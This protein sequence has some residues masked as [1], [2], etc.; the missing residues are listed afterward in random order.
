MIE[1]TEKSRVPF[2][3]KPDKGKK[4]CECS[5]SFL[6]WIV[7]TLWEGDFHVWAFHAKKILESRASLNQQI[8][9]EDQL[10]AM[11]DSLLTNAGYGKLC[12][13]RRKRREFS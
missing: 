3:R 4:L 11:A 2:G 5:D 12:S 7:E 13:K 8:A 6:R 10:E 9:T 1:I